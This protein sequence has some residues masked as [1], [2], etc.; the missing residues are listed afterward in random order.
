MAEAYSVDK[1]RLPAT[2]VVMLRDRALTWY[3]SNNQRWTSWEKFRTDFTRFF[4]PPRHLDGLEDDVRRRTQRPR[5][6]FQ[7]YVLA[8]QYTMRHTLMSE[9][10]QLERIYMKAQPEYL[11]YIRR[12]AHS[13]HHQPKPPPNKGQRPPNDVDIITL[14]R[15]T[16]TKTTTH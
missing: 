1:D 10:Q 2:M 13:D 9:G 14:Y 16:I 7:D 12:L 11:W 8:L 4:L 3:C 15:H 6:N 5:E